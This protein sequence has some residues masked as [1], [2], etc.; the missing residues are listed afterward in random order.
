MRGEEKPELL[1]SGPGWVI[2]WYTK[3]RWNLERYREDQPTPPGRAMLIFSVTFQCFAWLACRI[4]QCQFDTNGRGEPLLT[5]IFRIED[6]TSDCETFSHDYAW[7]WCDLA[8]R[9]LV[10]DHWLELSLSI[11]WNGLLENRELLIRQEPIQVWSTHVMLA[12]NAV[13]LSVWKH[14]P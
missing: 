10:L 11:A 9:K 14:F 6:S 13:R 8:G 5:W 12:L 3:P 2:Y 1:E 7:L 4:L